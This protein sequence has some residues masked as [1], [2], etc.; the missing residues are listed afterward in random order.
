MPAPTKRC[1]VTAQWHHS[2]FCP[3]PVSPQASERSESME[4]GEAIEKERRVQLVVHIG[5]WRPAELLS[6]DLFMVTTLPLEVMPE[7]MLRFLSLLVVLPIVG[8]SPSYCPF[9]CQKQEIILEAKGS[10]CLLCC[11]CHKA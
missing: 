5:K 11:R 7:F 9:P 4:L 6:V 3:V 8:C 1:Q 2:A 10:E